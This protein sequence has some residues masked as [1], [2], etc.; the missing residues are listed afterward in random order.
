[1]GPIPGHPAMLA[2]GDDDSKDLL[3][4]VKFSHP[5]IVDVPVELSSETLFQLALH[6][7]AMTNHTDFPFAHQYEGEQ[8]DDEQP[9]EA[10]LQSAKKLGILLAAI[11][12]Q[13]P[14]VPG[15][16]LLRRIF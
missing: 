15:I 1:M 8:S 4:S 11:A 10:D 6:D 9:C 12:E 2:A 13:A 16:L 7:M 14:D 5:A 3:P